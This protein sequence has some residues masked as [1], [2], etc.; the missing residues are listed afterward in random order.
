MN[1][2]NLEKPFDD[3]NVE[4]NN[5]QSDQISE[6][7]SREQ[8]KPRIK[9]VR[10]PVITEENFVKDAENAVPPLAWKDQKKAYDDAWENNRNQQLDDI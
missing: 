5:N 2:N 1:N 4:S 10:N 3:A 9:D 8:D 6:N 7:N